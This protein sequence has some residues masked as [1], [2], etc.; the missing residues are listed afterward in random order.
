MKINDPRGWANYDLRAIICTLL[1][2]VHYTMF[3]TKYLTSSLC[4]FKDLSE[5]DFLNVLLYTY[6][7]N[8]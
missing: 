5:D 1:L 4:E 7:E 2:N 6:K 3:H 8:L